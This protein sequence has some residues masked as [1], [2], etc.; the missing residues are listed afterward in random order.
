MLLELINRR[1]LMNLDQ[2]EIERGNEFITIKTLKIT[3]FDANESF[4][5][6]YFHRF[7]L[8][9]LMNGS[10]MSI[11]ILFVRKSFSTIRRFA[12]I[13]EDDRIVKEKGIVC[14]Y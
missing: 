3:R 12:V 10:N 11:E 6:S 1:R 2:M 8:R 5:R 4:H 7:F 14:S 9:S 13:S